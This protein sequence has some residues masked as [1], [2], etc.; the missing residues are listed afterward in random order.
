MGASFM[1]SSTRSAVSSLID[2]PD[3]RLD[4]KPGSPSASTPNSLALMFVRARYASMASPDGVVERR[5]EGILRLRFS[6]SG[7]QPRFGTVDDHSAPGTDREFNPG[8][9]PMPIP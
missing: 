4:T 5:H 7:G 2:R 9:A 1:N 3:L 6:V 8:A